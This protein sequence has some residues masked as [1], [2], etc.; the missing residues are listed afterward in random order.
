MA[1]ERNPVFVAAEKWLIENPRKPNGSKNTIRDWYKASGYDPKKNRPL[2]NRARAGQPP[3]I[4]YRYYA[5]ERGATQ[6]RLGRI[7]ESKKTVNEA[8]RVEAAAQWDELVG[9]RDKTIKIKNRT[10]TF[11][12]YLNK[13]VRDHGKLTR[14]KAAEAV[15]LEMSLGHGTPTTDVARYAE[16]YTQQFA[17]DPSANYASQDYV[18]PDQTER[19]RQAGL[20]GSPEEAAKLHVGTTDIGGRL[21]DTDIGEVLKGTFNLTSENGALRFARNTRFARALPIAGTVLSAGMVELNR[22]ARSEEIRQNPDDPTLKANLALEEVAGWADRATLSSLATGI[23]A[24]AAVPLEI[25]STGASVMSLIID[26]GRVLVKQM[27]KPFGDNAD[28]MPEWEKRQRS[29]MGSY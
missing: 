25:I 1:K 16:S 7:K 29:R 23:G 9:D 17:E 18:P 4:T 6:R 2:K 19:L 15:D 11:D 14:Q 20:A 27:Q 24:P 5:Q 12:Q 26:G 10:Y 13:E 3:S 28:K 8:I 21:P 22:A